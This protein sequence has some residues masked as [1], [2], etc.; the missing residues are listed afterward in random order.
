MQLNCGLVK[1]NLGG[2]TFFLNFMYFFKGDCIIRGHTASQCTL[3]EVEGFC[4]SPLFSIVQK[5]HKE[6][7]EQANGDYFNLKQ[8]YRRSLQVMQNFDAGLDMLQMSKNVL[9]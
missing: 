5:R 3:K 2:G 6:N 7:P 9:F 8:Y 4:Y 1:H